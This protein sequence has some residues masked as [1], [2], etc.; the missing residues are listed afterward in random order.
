[1]FDEGEVDSEK[2]GVGAGFTI[3]VVLAE[4]VS[5]PLVPVTVSVN[6]PVAAL[7]VV[8]AVNVDVPE[9]VTLVGLKLPL[10]P[11]PN[12]PTERFTVPANPFVAV[13]VVVYVALP[14][15]TTVAED[16]ETAIV[17]SGVALICVD[18]W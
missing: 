17:K 16:G 14:P 15:C 18:I 6:V 13:I 12:P 5:V 4:C 3:N 7:P 8:D 2:S 10:P 9:P 11:E 1:V